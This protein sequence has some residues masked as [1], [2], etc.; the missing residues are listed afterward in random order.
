MAAGVDGDN[1]GSVSSCCC[2]DDGSD[3][4]CEGEGEVPAEIQIQVE[5]N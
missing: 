5:L 4:M 3:A 2:D 1:K